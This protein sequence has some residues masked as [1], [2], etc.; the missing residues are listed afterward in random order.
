MHNNRS[1]YNDEEHQILMAKAR[2]RPI[3]NAHIGQRMD[4]PPVDF[5]A[6]AR[7]FGLEAWGPLED[8]TDLRPAFERAA[9]TVLR[10]RKTAL[11]DVISQPR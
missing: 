9:R 4:D 5:A 8:S 3:E 2:E 7:S 11:V 6:M 10:E 1:Y